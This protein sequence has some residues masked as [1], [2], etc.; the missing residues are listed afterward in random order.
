MWFGLAAI[1]LLGA[2]ALLYIDRSRRDQVGRVRQ[3][4]A[5]AQGYTYE[6]SDDDIVLQ[7]RRAALAKPEQTTAVDL[8]SG[9]RRG[10]KFVLFDVEETSTIVAVQRPV[11]SDVDIDLRL[12]ST[13]PPRDSDMELLGSIGPRV[14]FATNVEVARRV[15]DQRMAAFTESVPAGLNLLWSEND[16]TLGSLPLGSTGRDWDAAIDAVARLSGMLHV[17]PPVNNRRPS[18]PARTSPPQRG[19]P[20]TTVG[21]QSPEPRQNPEPRQAR[22]EVRRPEPRPPLRS[23]PVIQPSGPRPPSRPTPITRDS[24]RRRQD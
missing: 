11:G 12:K 22:P 9:V 19:R 21:R 7:F 24:D 5:K 8:V 2:V 6:A 20:E 13:P 10:E 14:V 4:W 3:M 23:G 15:C 1:A 17:L 18:G 16:W